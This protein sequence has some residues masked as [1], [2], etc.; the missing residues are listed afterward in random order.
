MLLLLLLLG[1]VAEGVERGFNAEATFAAAALGG[2]FFRGGKR[3]EAE[4][5]EGRL[6]VVLVVEFG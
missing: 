2:G 4:R 6:R 5:D 3:E 1:L